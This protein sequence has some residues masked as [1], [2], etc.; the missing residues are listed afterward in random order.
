MNMMS[1]PML[2]NDNGASLH[3]AHRR[4]DWERVEIDYRAGRLTL[5][6][7][8]AKHGVSHVAVQKRA[9]RESWDRDLAPRIQ[10]KAAALVAKQTAAVNNRQLPS[11]VNE[12]IVVNAEAELIAGI[13]NR[14]RARM[15]KLH[16]LQENAMQ[17]AAQA[18]QSVA[19]LGDMRQ[20]AESINEPDRKAAFL[21]QV[22]TLE[23]ALSADV[24]VVRVQRLT[25]AAQALGESEAEVYGLSKDAPAGSVPAGLS[26]FYP[27]PDQPA[28][29]S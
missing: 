5:R 29:G 7:I 21:A 8:G 6:E 20:M 2:G 18:A 12:N 4:I 9:K 24:Q 23:D 22:A 28:T 27:E 3:P 26:L 25:T 11:P 17:M 15:D 10:A 14:R 1:D 16:A 13:Q 19:L